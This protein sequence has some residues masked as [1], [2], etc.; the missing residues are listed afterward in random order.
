M[1]RPHRGTVAKLAAAVAVFAALGGGV[2]W[3]TIPGGNGLISACY[4][5]ANGAL[6]VIDAGKGQKCS[7]RAETALAWNQTGRS[8]PTGPTGA[9]GP[10]EGVSATPS[11]GPGPTTLT[12]QDPQTF[13]S[14]FTTTVSGKLSLSKPIN[15]TLQCTNGST[16]FL[17]WWITLDGV[18]VRSSVTETDQFAAPTPQTLVGVTDSAIAAGTHTLGAAAMCDTGSWV[19]AQSLPFSGG[20]V[21]VLG[22]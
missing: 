4:S 11:S 21:I 2:A 7:A 8:G 13:D 5:K 3:A 6:R 15:A 20:T 14:T 16:P 12:A 18:P 10:T 9:Q 22:Q 1:H 17:W 19:F